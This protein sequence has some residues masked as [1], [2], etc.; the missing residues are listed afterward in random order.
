MKGRFYVGMTRAK[1]Y[2]YLVS[3]QS[4]NGI[5]EPRSVFVN[6]VVACM[7]SEMLNKIGEGVIVHHK[8]FG[9]GF[10]AAVHEKV[11]DRTILEIDFRGM[12]RKLDLV[13]CMESGLLSFE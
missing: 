9:E 7:N 1:E 3:P 2:L 12:R 4:K 8:K 6:E 10:T 13:T 11:N 5:A